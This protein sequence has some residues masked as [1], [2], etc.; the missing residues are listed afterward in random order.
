MMPDEDVLD[1]GLISKAYLQARLVVALG[2]RASELV[3]FGPSEVTQGAAGDLEMVTR[4]CREMVTR[5]GFSSLGPQA[6]EGEGM[7]VFLGRDWL[8]SEPHYSQETGTRID[9]QVRVLANQALARALALLGPRRDLLDELVDKLI[10]EE[11]IE[12]DSFRQMVE[13]HEAG[14]VVS[15]GQSTAEADIQAAQVRV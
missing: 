7:E 8:R 1:S 10:T 13:A 5:F 14:R 4:I 3:V 12:G 2:G 6:L 15:A 11:T 9:Q